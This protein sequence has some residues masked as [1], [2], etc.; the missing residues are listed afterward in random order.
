MPLIESPP[1]YAAAVRRMHWTVF[2][3]VLLAYVCINL[4]GQFPKGSAARGNILAAHYTA[5]LAVLLL[6][7]PRL[8]L[9]LR[10]GRPSILP[11]PPRW[12]ELLGKVTHVSLYLFLLIQPILGI[13]TLQIGGKPVT[14]FGLTLLPSFVDLP[15]RVLSHQLEDIHGT[16]GTIFY[17]V[18][19]LHILAALWHH[20]GRRDSTLKRML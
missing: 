10:H 2:V 19:G 20:F 7:L 11:P 14:L 9:R 6:V 4:F 12:T 17:Y 16:I 13:I 5:G 3:L 15:N 1:R 8:L 18:I